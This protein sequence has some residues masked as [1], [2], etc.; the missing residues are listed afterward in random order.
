MKRYLRYVPIILV[1][2]ALVVAVTV[3]WPV[4]LPFFGGGGLTGGGSGGGAP[5]AGGAEAGEPGGA[6][7]SGAGVAEGQPAVDAAALGG[8]GK[9]AFVWDGDLYVLD[10]KAKT[11]VKV[12][13]SGQAAYPVWSADGRWLAYLSLTGETESRSGS[14]WV[15]AADGTK[16]HEVQGLPAPVSGGEFVWSPAENRLVVKCSD[17][18]SE[19]PLRGGLWLVGTSGAPVSLPADGAVGSFAWSPD[20]SE[21][22]YSLTPSSDTPGPLPSDVLYTLPVDG[23]AAAATPAKVYEAKDGS[24]IMMAGFWPDGRG[25]VFWLDPLHSASLAA[26]GLPLVSLALG[27][28]EPKPLATTL[29]NPGWLSAGPGNRLAVTEGTGRIEWSSKNLAVCDLAAGSRVSLA[30]PAGCVATDPAWSPDGRTIAFVAAKDLGADSWGFPGE[31]GLQAWVDSRTLWITGPDGLG[32]RA[33]EVAG[34]GVYDPVWTA[35][36]GSLLYI[37]SGAVWRIGL[38]GKD[39][40]KVVG[41]FPAAK[42][43]FGFYGQ[44]DWSAELAWL[45]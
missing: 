45:P 30:N 41:P 29:A 40:L 12:S 8:A 23:N 5:E 33:L 43:L 42:D 22:A 38:D 15:V 14:L 3:S 1:A 24:G 34:R 16:A 20:G 21:I 10:G 26:D 36:G 7:G 13:A 17:E 35:D 6:D 9:L 31:E 27:G 11:C 32:A 18:T 2:A 19:P 25:L 28:G 39:P 4:Q 37:R 44:V